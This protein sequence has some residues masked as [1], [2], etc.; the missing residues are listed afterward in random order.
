MDITDAANKTQKRYR[1]NN[2]VN[3]MFD[4]NSLPAIQKK[5]NSR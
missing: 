1:F 5:T 3:N 4:N 2:V